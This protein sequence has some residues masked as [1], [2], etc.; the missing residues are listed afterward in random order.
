MKN[1][2]CSM[3]WRNGISSLGL[4]SFYSTITLY[5][6]LHYFTGSSSFILLQ[7]L[8]TLLHVQYSFLHLFCSIVVKAQD[9]LWCPSW[10]CQLKQPRDT[11]I[12]NINLFSVHTL[13]TFGYGHLFLHKCIRLTY[14]N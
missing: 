6:T 2:P 9:H 1:T 10:G 13:P 12:T 4:I 3:A 8:R 14:V 11:L 7:L 5:V